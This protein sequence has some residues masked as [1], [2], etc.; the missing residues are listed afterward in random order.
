MSNDE[1]SLPMIHSD[2]VYDLIE[3]RDQGGLIKPSNAVI[4]I[5]KQTES[6]LRQ[7]SNDDF[8]RKSLLHR[9]TS[10]VLNELPVPFPDDHESGLN[11]H[12]LKLAKLVI[13]NYVKVRMHHLCHLRSEQ[14]Q[15]KKIRSKLTRAIILLHQ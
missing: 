12:S 1:E 15:G 14:A 4:Q 8:C 3:M 10:A 7:M 6:V 5:C 11:S 13:D 9:I 2:N